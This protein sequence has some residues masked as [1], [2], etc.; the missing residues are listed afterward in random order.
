MAQNRPST[1]FSFKSA[2]G[3]RAMDALRHQIERT[4]VGGHRADVRFRG[5]DNGCAAAH[6]AFHGVP[7]AGVNTG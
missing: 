5:T 1:S 6:K 4:H 7:S 3:Q 2:I